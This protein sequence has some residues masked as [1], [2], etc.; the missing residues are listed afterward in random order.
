L[1]E[2]AYGTLWRPGPLIKTVPRQPPERHKPR[3]VRERG[4]ETVHT[5]DEMVAE[6][7]YRPTACRRS[8][9]VVVHRKLLAAD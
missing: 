7:A 3:I 8:Y 1:P 2:S 4:F 6:F 5:L 9:R